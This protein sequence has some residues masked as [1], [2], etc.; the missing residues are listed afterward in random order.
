MTTTE[1]K[2]ES[3]L[4]KDQPTQLNQWREL[5]EIA[6]EYLAQEMASVETGQRITRQ[7]DSIRSGMG[8]SENLKPTVSTD[9]ELCSLSLELARRVFKGDKA[10]INYV[11]ACL[12]YSE[13]FPAAFNKAE[14]EAE[15]ALLQ[16]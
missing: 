9:I 6:R 14:L 7:I 16:Q 13:F 4:E 15:I 12:Y 1:H 3:F 5:A 11:D 8:A 2:L 10:L